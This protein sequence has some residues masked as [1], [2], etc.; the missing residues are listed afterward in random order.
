MPHDSLVFT[1][2]CIHE[3]AVN[4]VHHN[5]SFETLLFLYSLIFCSH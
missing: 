5:T 3:V 2:V 4:K 1:I